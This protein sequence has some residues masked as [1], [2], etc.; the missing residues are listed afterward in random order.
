MA[1]SSLEPWGLCAQLWEPEPLGDD[2]GT[3]WKKAQIPKSHVAEKADDWEHPPRFSGF[4]VSEISFLVFEPL[5]IFVFVG[6]T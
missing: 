5:F 6:T 4:Y 1:L 3:K 2:G